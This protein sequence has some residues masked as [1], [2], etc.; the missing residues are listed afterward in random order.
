MNRIDRCFREL[1]ESG[2]KALITY[3]TAG[4]PDMRTTEKVVLEMFD[5]GADMVELGVPF[6]DPIAE[7][8]VIQKASLRSLENGTT[9]DTV[10]EA[11][12]NIRKLTDKPLVLM[13]YLNTIF[14]YGTEKFFSLC[15]DK[16]I[17]GV[18]VPD[19]PFEE[20]DEI[21]PCAEKYGVHA[22]SCV[23]SAS[24]SRAAAIAENSTGFLYC[25]DGAAVKGACPC[26]AELSEGTDI[27]DFDGVIVSSEIVKLMD[28]ADAV[29][30]S[31][32]FVAEL[33]QKIGKASPVAV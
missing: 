17:D 5:K 3:I 31:G 14:V 7:D 29:T 28:G 11:V 16:G 26:C 12:D 25:I 6:S 10:F 8:V 1:A 22:I 27:S 9:L 18:I 4:A 32:R 21:L 24:A 23:S 20:R 15:R 2:E 30:A 19:M 33:A 13:M